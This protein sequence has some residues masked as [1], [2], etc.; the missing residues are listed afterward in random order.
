MVTLEIVENES[1]YLFYTPQSLPDTSED[2]QDS[3]PSVHA[4]CPS[5]DQVKHISLHQQLP[6][7]S[8]GDKDKLYS[9]YYI[10]WGYRYQVQ[11]PKVKERASKYSCIQR[12]GFV[13]V[14][15]T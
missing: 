3:F 8:C 12:N 11:L 7:R 10:T 13:I 14:F 1:S 5:V 4:L 6:F 15:S 9:D 2:Q